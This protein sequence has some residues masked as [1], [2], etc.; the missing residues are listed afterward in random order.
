MLP[1]CGAT[2]H[3][4]PASSL[5]QLEVERHRYLSAAL[6]TTSLQVYQTALT[7]YLNFCIQVGVNPYPLQEHVVELFSTSLACR[8]GYKTIKAYLYGIQFHG[9]IRG[10]HHKITDMPHLGYILHDIRRTQGACH[11]R[12]R[13]WPI[14]LTH[15]NYVHIGRIH[16]KEDTYMLKAAITVAYFGMLRVSEYTCTNVHRYDAERNLMRQDIYAMQHMVI[17]HIKSSKTDPFR[18]GVSI[19]IVATSHTICPVWWVRAF[20]QSQR[21]S[22]G[23]LFM[24]RSGW[25][26]VR[27]DIAKLIKNS[28]DE[29]NLN[30]HSLRG[31]AATNLA[32]LGVPDYVIQMMVR[33]RSDAYKR[34]LHFSDAYINQLHARMATPRMANWKEWDTHTTQSADRIEER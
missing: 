14:T 25:F 16:H 7:Q 19:R 15:K 30:T 24:F 13:R 1:R 22:Y 29:I 4:G 34:Y 6:A 21:E 8:V 20:L 23:L 17:I 27:S 2:S 33:W 12:P 26:L 28:L 9:S 32:N 5:E 11:S 3:T 31:G 10:H 18:V